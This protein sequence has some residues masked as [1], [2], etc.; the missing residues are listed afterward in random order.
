M[1]LEYKPIQNITILLPKVLFKANKP[2]FLYGKCI[3]RESV[4]KF[5]VIS[6]KE[7]Q[8]LELI[9]AIDEEFHNEISKHV[10]RLTSST[11]VE[12]GIRVSF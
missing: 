1:S 6:D 12:E 5:Y 11:D 4:V 10:F 7:H 2:K 9:G 8:Q 3:Q